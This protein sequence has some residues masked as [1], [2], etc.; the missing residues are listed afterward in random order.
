MILGNGGA[1]KAIKYALDNLNI[2]HQTVSRKKGKSDFTY[3][4]LNKKIIHEFK[5]KKGNYSI[6]S[7]SDETEQAKKV[8]SVS[9]E[10]GVLLVKNWIGTLWQNTF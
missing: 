6:Y 7:I 9:P 5:V 8:Y 3:D 2:E 4:Q 10:V 1:T